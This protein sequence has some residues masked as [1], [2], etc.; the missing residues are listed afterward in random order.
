MD[1]KYR[2]SLT[3][4]AEQPEQQSERHSNSESSDFFIAGISFLSDSISTAV[5]E[6]V[7]SDGNDVDYCFCGAG[8]G[9]SN[10]SK[11]HG[12]HTV[13]S[14][15]GTIYHQ[16]D[17]SPKIPIPTACPKIISRQM[18]FR[19][20]SFGNASPSRWADSVVKSVSRKMQS[21]TNT[22]KYKASAR[23]VR[24]GCETLAIVKNG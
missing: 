8:S 21:K 3:C 9:G 6:I 7:E 10:S 18:P 22:I 19:K 1:C 14:T 13:N 16:L 20:R 5:V 2:R 23:W 24:N 12:T 4:V 11:L 15:I 17:E